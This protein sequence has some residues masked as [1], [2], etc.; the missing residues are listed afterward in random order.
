MRKIGVKIVGIIIVVTLI[1]HG[2]VAIAAVS[3]E[4]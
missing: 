3:S 2:N 1:L 4:K